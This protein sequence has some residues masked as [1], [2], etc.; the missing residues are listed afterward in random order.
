MY[1]ENPIDVF[2]DLIPEANPWVTEE[3][4]RKQGGMIVWDIDD[5]GRAAPDDW[6]KRFPNAELLE[7][8]ECPTRALTGDVP[9]HVGVLLV[10]PDTPR[11]AN[12]AGQDSLR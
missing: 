5:P 11:I 8:L 2:G 6:Q 10:H 12:R 9:A 7:P 1:S 4:L 3:R